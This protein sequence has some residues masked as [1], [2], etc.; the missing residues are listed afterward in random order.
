MPDVNMKHLTRVTS[1]DGDAFY[2]AATIT[3]DSEY[4]TEM[5]S[6]I[7]YDGITSSASSFPE[8]LFLGS[9]ESAFGIAQIVYSSI[10]KRERYET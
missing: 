1:G 2:G 5:V 10:V 3:S 4:A 8:S 6:A 9:H 7:R